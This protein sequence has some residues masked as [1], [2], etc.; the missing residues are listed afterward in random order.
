M[1][2]YFNCYCCATHDRINNVFIFYTSKPS[3]STLGNHK[4]SWSDSTNYL[5]LAYI[6]APIMQY[7]SADIVITFVMMCVCVYVY[8]GMHVCD[9][10]TNTSWSI[11]H[12][13]HPS[14]TVQGTRL[15]KSESSWRTTIKNNDD[16][17]KMFAVVIARLDRFQVLDA[18]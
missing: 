1:S 15:N 9:F 2:S 8:V 6:P 13:C 16:Q 7:S 11:N 4:T 10:R 5:H 17:L 18:E 12:A 3:S 14:G